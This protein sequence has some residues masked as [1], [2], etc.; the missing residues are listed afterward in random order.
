[1]I[2]YDPAFV[3]DH[4]KTLFPFS[5]G[6]S[7]YPG[8]GGSTG[9][10]QTITLWTLDVKKLLGRKESFKQDF[11]LSRMYNKPELCFRL[12]QAVSKI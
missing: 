12:V 2:T 6:P 10:D 1:M 8:Q 7:M 11:V 9:P 4:I 5:Q 3:N